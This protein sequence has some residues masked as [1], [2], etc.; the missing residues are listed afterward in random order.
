M[1]T[2]IQSKAGLAGDYIADVG[3]QYATV[4][5]SAN[6]TTITTKKAILGN[7]WVTVVLSA[8]ACPIQDNTTE[9]ISFAAS[10][11]VGTTLTAQKDTQCLGGIVVDP[12]D[13]ATGT[14]VVQYREIE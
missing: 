10:A 2:Q 4:D 6:S 12:N 9:I 11:A 1:A 8:H 7:A 5:L 14:I 13:S 3:W